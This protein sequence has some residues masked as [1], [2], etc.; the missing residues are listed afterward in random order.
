M[1]ETE[2][3]ERAAR[4]LFPAGYTNARQRFRQAACGASAAVISYS[5]P[6]SGPG[7]EQLSTDVAVIGPE[8]AGQ[9]FVLCSATH[10]VEGF[11]GSAIQTSILETVQP[12][13]LPQDTKL[14][15]VHAINPWGYAHLRRAN[16]DNIDLNRNFRD[17]GSPVP[18][19]IGYE[20]MAGHLNPDSL[21]GW[22]DFGFLAALFAYRA[23]NGMAA[24]RHVV[25]AGQYS[26]P[27]GLFF[28]GTHSTW[29]AETL[30]AILRL[31]T[32][33][34]REL[35]F[36]DV[37]TGLG[38]YKNSEIILNVPRDDPPA[39]RAASIWGNKVKTTKMNESVSVDLTG[40]LKLAVPALVPHANVVAASLEFG[41]VPRL[42][43]LRTLRAE[44]WLHHHGGSNHKKASLIK[45]RLVETFSPSLNDWKQ[46]VVRTGHRVYRE[47]LQGFGKNNGAAY[48]FDGMS[49]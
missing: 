43:A 16:E 13:R 7:G 4:R 6:L 49:Q 3:S 15:L 23:T 1:R 28:G 17:H 27:K 38:A 29:S 47:V 41:T 18:A 40:S 37:H 35:V 20:R 8:N 12:E 14:I 24:T 2:I 31:H 33:G 34:A 32:A 44:N 26:H 46:V 30:T 5:H 42:K 36:L 9:V 10:G 39:I 48:E 22:S 11:P 19:N 25:T 45:R 21:S